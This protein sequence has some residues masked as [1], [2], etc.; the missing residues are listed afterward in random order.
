MR[1]LPLTVIVLAAAAGTAFA[2]AAVPFA[3][4]PGLWQVTSQ[5]SGATLPPSARAHLTPQQQTQMLAAMSQANVAKEC[6]TAADFAKAMTS[7]REGSSD[8]ARTV[9]SQ[10][11]T[12]MSLHVECKGAHVSS[13]GTFN[14]AFISPTAFRG[15]V[16][17][18]LTMQGRQPQNITTTISGT[19]LGADCGHIKPGESE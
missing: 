7:G 5:M 10:S 13:V 18:Q 1:L 15:T 6:L 16:S 17:M 12:A 9:V 4:K 19:W 14:V 11:P 8:C 3:G 2:A